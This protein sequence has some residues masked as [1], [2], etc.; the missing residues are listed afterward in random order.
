MNYLETCNSPHRKVIREGSLEARGAL[1]R[2]LTL[3]LE[4]IKVAKVELAI[5]KLL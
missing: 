4:P 1:D 3:L 2:S 5:R